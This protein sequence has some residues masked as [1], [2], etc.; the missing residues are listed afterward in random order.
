ML[1]ISDSAS[2][3]WICAHVVVVQINA[4]SKLAV[5]FLKFNIVFVILKYLL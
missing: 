3:L 2:F 1:K 4:P 5:Y